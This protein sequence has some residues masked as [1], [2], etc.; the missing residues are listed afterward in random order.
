MAAVYGYN[1]GTNSATNGLYPSEHN[2]SIEVSLH[3]IKVSTGTFVPK[4]YST[5]PMYNCTYPNAFQKSW[6]IKKNREG[7]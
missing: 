4:Y 5:V 1:N 2:P 7:E 6:E 3:L